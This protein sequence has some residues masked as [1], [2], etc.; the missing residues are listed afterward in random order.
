MIKIVAISD[1]HN[2]FPILPK[3]DILI[4][5]GD[6]TMSGSHR[7]L[8]K[9]SDWLTSIRKDFKE[10]YFMAG[11]HDLM[12]DSSESSIAVDYIRRSGATYVQDQFVISHGLRMYFTPWIPMIG[13]EPYWA[14][15]CRRGAEIQKKWDE[16]PEELDIL[17]TH[18]PPYKILDKGDNRENFGCWDLMNTLTRKME[19][20]PKR[21]IFGHI[22]SANSTLETLKTKFYNVS[23][24]NEHYELTYPPTV[25]EI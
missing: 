1:Y 24:M 21:H 20:P 6:A 9:L 7:E 5:A 10:I 16:I 8:Q 14:F 13:R 3:G 18:G 15:E 22:H 17:I 12:F 25:I 19:R 2:D 11:N 23:C 4:S